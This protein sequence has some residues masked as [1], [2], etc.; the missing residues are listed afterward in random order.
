MTMTPRQILGWIYF[1]KRYHERR[2][3]RE[4]R[5]RKGR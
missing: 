4:P 3:P 1:L 5:R 2:T